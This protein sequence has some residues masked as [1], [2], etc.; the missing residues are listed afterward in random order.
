MFLALNDIQRPHEGAKEGELGISS[1]DDWNIPP[2]IDWLTNNP[3]LQPG[4]GVAP[5]AGTPVVDSAETQTAKRKASSD[6]RDLKLAN[7]LG[8][9]EVPLDPYA[10]RVQKD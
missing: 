6:V 8:Y 1:P 9:S 7:T 3:P 2:I 5:G 4:D 10:S